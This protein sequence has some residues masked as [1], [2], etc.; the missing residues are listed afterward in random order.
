MHVRPEGSAGTDT[1]AVST[2]AS[3]ASAPAVC[4][5]HRYASPARGSGFCYVKSTRAGSAGSV[6]PARPVTCGTTSSMG[7]C[8]AYEAPLGSGSGA[9]L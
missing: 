7:F 3:E 2:G 9:G 1:F 5:P 6:V 4:T 8:G